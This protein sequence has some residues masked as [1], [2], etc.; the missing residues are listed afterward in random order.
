LMVLVETYGC[1]ANKVDTQIMRAILER[2]GFKTTTDS[3]LEGM[4][5]AVVINSCTVKDRTH[6]RIVKRSASLSGRPLVVAGCLAASSPQDLPPNASL[7][8]PSN[9]ELIS[10][11]VKEAISGRRAVFIDGTGR[12]APD[13]ACLPIKQWEG[14]IAAVSV[15]EG[16]VGHCTYCSTRTARGGLHS[17]SAEAVAKKVKSHV[18]AGAREVWLT[19]QDLGAYGKDRD[20]KSTL[21]GLLEKIFSTCEGLPEFRIRAG[22]MNPN[23]FMDESV[24]EGVLE[25]FE[26][27]RLFKF[28]H[29]PVQSGSDRVLKL[30]GRE[31]SSSDFLEIV[32]RI[33]DRFPECTI[34]TDV[35]LGFPGES[36]EDFAKSMELVRTTRPF[37]LNISKYSPRPGTPAAGL[38]Q[39]LQ[40]TVKERSRMLTLL[41]QEIGRGILKP[42]I[43]ST[44]RIIVDEKG[45]KGVSGRTDSYVTVALAGR[46]AMGIGEFVDAKI[47][48]S[49]HHYLIGSVA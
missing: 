12:R 30:M 46:K 5:D 25:K 7:V 14:V 33:R 2:D 20:R 19:S 35:I 28:F 24:L 11:A 17:F 23:H 27:P 15:S 8:S 34:A 3:R 1:T 47:E 21:S 39:I 31:Y 48:S 16:C 29:I 41:H 4:A 43:G 13:K 45:P 6:N 18:E 26:D 32:S 36:D 37:V 42:F 38:K 10:E 22:M 40:R 9:V 49:T 44:V